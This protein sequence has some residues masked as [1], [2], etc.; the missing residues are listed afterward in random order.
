MRRAG[1]QRSLHR[2]AR[3]S[4]QTKMRLRGC[5]ALLQRAGGLL[6]GSEPAAAT[7]QTA[8][9]PYAAAAA[10]A[11]A[12]TFVR[13]GA[14]SKVLGRLLLHLRSAFLTPACLAIICC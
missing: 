14:A 6:Q 11:A 4:T 3:P 12:S 7:L 8:A 2:G 5:A 10:A 9:A 1:N 13:R